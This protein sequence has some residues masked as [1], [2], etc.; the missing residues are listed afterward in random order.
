MGSRISLKPNVWYD[1]DE[2]KKI[3]LKNLRFK[4]I[5]AEEELI[6]N[7]YEPCNKNDEGS[8]R[9][10]ALEILQELNEN[11]HGLRLT[12]EA[13]GKV[14]SAKKF[15]QVAVHGKR[16]WVFKRKSANTQQ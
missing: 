13:I 4:S 5:S 6:L 15:K 16:F 8:V 3:E 12:A 1:Y 14:M 7:Y 2:I 11:H 9:R 10:T